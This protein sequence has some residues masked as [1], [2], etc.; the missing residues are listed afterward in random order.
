MAA[1]GE[2]SKLEATDIVLE[3][4]EQEQILNIL[5]RSQRGRMDEQCCT[6]S[7]AKTAQ[8][9]TTPTDSSKEKSSHNSDRKNGQHLDPRVSLPGFNYQEPGSNNHHGSAPQISL[10]ESTPERNRR[11]LGVPGH[12]L[13]VPS[14]RARSNSIKEE[15]HEEQQR[16]LNMITQGQR[17]RM[18]DQSCSL[19]PSRSAPC[20]PKHTDRKSASLNTDSE[21]LFNLLAST[22]S[23]R[24]DDQRVSLPSLPGLQKEKNTS[25]GDSSFLY[26]MVSQAQGS[27]M[28]DQRCSL[29]PTPSR[30]TSL[31]PS[32][33]TERPK[34]KDKTSEKQVVTASEQEDFFNLM[35]H[36][37]RGRMDEQRCVLSVTPQSTPKHQL[38]QNTQPQGIQNGG[39]TSSST[40]AAAEMDARY[41]CY[42]V[43][44][45]QGSRMDEQRCSAPQISQN[46]GT[47]S[48][49]RKD[50]LNSDTSLRRSASLNRSKTDDH[51]Q[52]TSEAEQEQFLQMIS[53]AQSGRMDEQ[54]CSLQPSRSTSA[55]P[56][57][58]GSAL[59]NVPTGAEA[60]AFF[61]TIASSQGGRLDD[62]RFTLPTLPGI[63][64]N[65]E[66]KKN[67]R[68][69]MA[70]IPASP[71]HIMVP[72][73]TPQTTKKTSSSPTSQPQRA[74][75]ESGSVGT[76]PKS[77]SFTP[78]T[79]NQKKL[80]SS[81]QVTVRVSM[82]FTP[83]QGQTEAN[84]PVT[85]P[86]VYLTLGAP[87]D[88]L[89]IPLSPVPG[90]PLSLDLNLVPKEDVNSRHCSPTY[91]S[92][93]KA[94][95]K[96]S[97][98]NQRA[99]SKAHPVTACSQEEGKIVTS[100]ISPDED[101]FS[102]IEKIHTA[103]LQKGM[104]HGGQKIKEDLDKGKD[105]AERGKGA[106]KKD[107]KNNGNK[108]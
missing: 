66:G 59:N 50:H 5:S 55:T 94:H 2:D 105:K 65:S 11:L 70:K 76:I 71:P 45:V 38:S 67:A 91:V 37:Q 77:A 68:S 64:G 100:P 87:G 106:G 104:A 20:T 53:H 22:Q 28:E 47:P 86:E 85:F 73:R 30:S 97:S 96:P 95:S 61:N 17:G 84:Q 13:P 51:R 56:T 43:S 25:D 4:P 108:Q 74:Y 58:N 101:C 63:G 40:S 89:V 18:D 44:K 27:R 23:Q 79:E 8:I 99:I 42:M 82:S 83:P 31:S 34:S 107:K 1:T 12:E 36:S 57:H 60:N 69:T 92:P 26:N 46:L 32:S 75:A 19:D 62:Q 98:P 35:S 90:R 103:Q 16:F 24:L 15:T 7:P 72:E 3:S 21:M 33:D 93:T 54:R 49:Q 41:L 6:L 10:T 14:D 81:A 88:N 9:K 29:P 80:N 52:E 48:P 78:E 102:L 39:T